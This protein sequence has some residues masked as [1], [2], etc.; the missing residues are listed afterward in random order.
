M[1]ETGYPSIDKKHLDGTKFI[2]RHPII[3]SI[4]LSNAMDLT[5]ITK[6]NDYI[7]NCLDL[8]VKYKELK[9]DAKIISQAFSELG[10]KNKDII[11]ISTPNLYQ[12]V[13]CFKAANRIGATVTFLN[14]HAPIE[15]TEKYLNIYN[16]TY[17]GNNTK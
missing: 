4:S 13:V 14:S 12:S 9:E 17:E 6:Q 15:E 2:E 5:N 10:V 1:K 16:S 11:C 3:P 7:I 8:R